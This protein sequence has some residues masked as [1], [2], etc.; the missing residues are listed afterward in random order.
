MTNG[1]WQHWESRGFLPPL[2]IPSDYYPSLGAYSSFDPHAVAQHLAWLRQSGVGVIITSWWGQGSSEDKA[3]PILLEQ[4][5]RYGIKVAFHLEPYHGRSADRLIEDVEYLY[6]QYGNHSAFYRTSASSGWSPD[7][8]PKGLFFLYASDFPDS[9]ALDGHTGR[10]R[11]DYWL[12]AV[13]AIHS[14]VQ[15]GLIIASSF[16]GNWIDGGHFDGVYN[17]ITLHPEEEGGFSWAQQ[18]PPVAWYIPSVMP[19]NS[20]RRIGYPEDTYV[21]RNEGTTYDHQW[22]AALSAGVEPSMVTITSFNEW[23]EGSQIEP[24]AVGAT[25]R[26]GYN[27]QD[28]GSLPPDGYLLLTR[29]W[30]GQ[31]LSKEWPQSY[32]LRIRILTTSDWTTFSLVEGGILVRPS[33]VSASEEADYAWPERGRFLLTQPLSQAEHGQQLELTVDVLLTE[34]SDNTL[35]RVEV[36]RGHLGLTQVELFSLLDGRPVLVDTIRWGGIVSGERNAL[37]RELSSSRYTNTLP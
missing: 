3:V 16:G 32:P 1:S 20:A 10:V 15:G 22:E 9:A 35:L 19:G 37:S 17:Y 24:A 6:S 12:E 2:D 7:Q 13:D 21:P 31:F 30:V 14:S 18:L 36:E 11:P 27:Y 4:G 25:N 34:V 29:R 5:A 28:Y 23:H 33:L 8:R 26:R